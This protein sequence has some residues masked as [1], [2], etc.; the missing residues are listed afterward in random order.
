MSHDEA[1]ARELK[2]GFVVGSLADDDIAAFGHMDREAIIPMTVGSIFRIDSLTKPIVAVALLTLLEEQKVSLDAPVTEWLPELENPQVLLDPFGELEQTEQARRQISVEDILTSRMGTGILL[3]PPASTPI[4]RAIAEQD[5]VGFGPPDPQNPLTADEWVR[6]LGA[7]PLLAQPGQSWF[8]NASSMVQ[9]VLVSRMSGMSLGL[10]LQERVFGPLD[11]LDTFFSVP[12]SRVERLTSAYAADLSLVDDR[13]NS[14]WASPP[15][16]EGSGGLL[17]TVPDF[18]KFVAML[19]GHRA[20]LVGEEWF[21][22][23]FSDH[24]TQDQRN[25]ASV[26]LDGRGWGYGVS[27]DAERSSEGAMEGTGGWSGGAGTSWVSSF[28]KD[29]AVVVFSNRALDDP[30]VYADHEA[31]H[32]KA[33]S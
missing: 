23:M 30:K 18:L 17:S 26:F 6:R 7:L 8:Y 33:L 20:R 21:A 10:Y 19:H 5:L 9:G 11:M 28:A 25:A 14:A 29:N 16:F 2:P 24:L 4:Q 27:V 12:A 13:Q 32:R 1:E 31:L 3:A 15:A 22:R